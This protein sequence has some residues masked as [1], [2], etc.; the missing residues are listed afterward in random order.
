M[1]V[2]GHRGDRR[3]MYC[4]SLPPRI[5]SRSLCDTVALGWGTFL[6]EMFLVGIRG[7]GIAKR[8]Y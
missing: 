4:D 3:E 6:T 8:S 1:F 2:V 5:K 7:G